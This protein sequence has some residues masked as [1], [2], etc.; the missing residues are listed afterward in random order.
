MEL[1]RPQG[2]AS[3]IGQSRSTGCDSDGNSP[4]RV[5]TMA[6]NCWARLELGSAGGVCVGSGLESPQQQVAVAWS[7]Q[8]GHAAL[9]LAGVVT[10]PGSH[11][12]GLE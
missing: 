2:C 9:V 11:T 3:A 6:R 12:N 5:G 7:A 10:G 8:H 4:T 1:V